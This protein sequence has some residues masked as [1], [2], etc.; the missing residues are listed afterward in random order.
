LRN[1]DVLIVSG[2]TPELLRRDL[3]QQRQT[4]TSVPAACPIA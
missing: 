2:D 1:S 4:G 3:V